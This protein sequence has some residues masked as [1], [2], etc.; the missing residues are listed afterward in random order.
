MRRASPALRFELIGP[1]HVDAVVE[2]FRRNAVAAVSHSFDPFPL[3][4]AQARSIALEPHE[5]AYY[6]ASEGR[7]PVGMS[8]LR[9][10]EQG[11]QIPSFGIL[12]DR[13]H[14]GQG[15]GRRLTEWTIEQAR[16]RSCPALRLSVYADNAAAHGLYLSLGFIERE[17]QVVQRES[18]PREK[19]VMRLELDG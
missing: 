17:R 19:L 5:D 18:R 7:A 9:G 13:E 4:P 16:L 15:I 2:L 6:L 1:E 10:F 12:V 11:F 8:M 3:T 14:Y